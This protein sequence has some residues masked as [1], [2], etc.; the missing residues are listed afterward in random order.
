MK[1]KIL[2]SLSLLLLLVSCNSNTIYSEFKNDFDS[3]RWLKADAKTFEFTIDEDAQLY[4]I[5]FDFSHVYDYQFSSIPINFIIESPNSLQEKFTIDL[6]IKDNSGKDIGDCSGDICDLKFKI[7]EKYK[8]EKGK[9]KVI[10][11]NNFKAD[12]LPNVIGVG[13]DV[14][15]LK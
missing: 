3:N 6:K 11:S 8:L 2:L 13:L 7:K 9:Y 10:I 12:Y 15:K 14:E 5:I 4:D 1:T